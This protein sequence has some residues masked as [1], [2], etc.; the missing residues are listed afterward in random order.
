MSTVGL[1]QPT[2]E[3][4]R[5]DWRVVFD[6]VEEFEPDRVV[7]HADL[8]KELE[9]KD[10]SRMYRAV[11][12]ANRELWASRQKSLAAVKGVG[13]RMLRAEEMERLANSY[14]RQ[15]R[16]KLSSAVAVIDATNLSQLTAT[17][18]EWTVK[19]QSAFHL[20]GQAM[21]LHASKLDRH[22]DLIRG[23]QDRVKRLEAGE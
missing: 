11:G 22:E 4:G 2:R 8:L 14:R 3:D 23:L 20:L 7:T 16:R 13:Y 15:S 12:R 5:A 19:V 10:R 18:R 6:L 1:F 21:D 17:Q 9:T